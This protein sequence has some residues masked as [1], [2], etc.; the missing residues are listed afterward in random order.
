VKLAINLPLAVYWQTL[1]EALTLCRS[2]GLDEARLVDVIGDSSAGPNVLKN[3][4]E[5]VAKALSGE[6]VP[7]TF[8][9]D[10]MRK[11]LKTMLAEAEGLGADLP[12]TKAALACYEES[13]AAG[14][15]GQDG[16][17]QSAFWRDRT[18]D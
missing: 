16:A 17:R 12:I 4:A 15:G 18:E 1:G 10:G 6:P 11:D 2:L 13:A 3:R 5:V 9:I 7:G 14:L 8:D